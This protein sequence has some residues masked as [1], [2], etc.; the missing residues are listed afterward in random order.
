MFSTSGDILNLVLA[1]CII[2]LTVF[3]VTALY[4]VVS[5]VRKIFHLVDKV[6]FGVN[7]AE[8]VI[9]LVRDKIKSGSAYAM[10]LTEAVKQVLR[11]VNDNGW[12]HKSKKKEKT[13][14]KK[15]SK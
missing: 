12:L 4:Y 5:G 11:V 1:V 3:L 7:K 13:K 6:E 14:N 10:L 9:T 2:V 15:E 8:E